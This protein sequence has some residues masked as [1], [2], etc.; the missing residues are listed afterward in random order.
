MLDND[1]QLGTMGTLS[2]N[3]P[4]TLEVSLGEGREVHVP[5][6]QRAKPGWVRAAALENRAV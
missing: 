2:C 3:Q 1:F 5:L 4:I 6:V